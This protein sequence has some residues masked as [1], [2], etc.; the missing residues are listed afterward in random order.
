[1]IGDPGMMSEGL[2]DGSEPMDPMA[3]ESEYPTAPGDE[4]VERNRPEPTPQRKALVDSLQKMVK[5]GKEHWDK[6]FRQME[7]DQRFCAGDQWPSE[8]KALAFNDS[9]DDRYVANI[10]L[11]H[12]QQKVASLYAKNPKV[13][14]RKRTKLLNTVWDGSMQ[15]LQQA[16]QTMQ[17][18]QMAQQAMMMMG[19]SM[20][21]GA[22]MPGQAP[23]APPGPNGE[24]GAPPPMPMPPPQMPDE[25]AV[26]EAQAVI[27]DAK[28]VKAQLEMQDRIARTLELLYQYEIDEQPSPFKSMMK[29]VIRRAATSGVG[30]IKLGFQRVMEPNAEVETRIADMQQ[31]LSTIER[32]SADIADNEVQTDGAEVEQLRLL[33]EDL[34]KETEIVV[35][36]GLLLT[37]PKPTAVIPDPRCVEL[38]SFLN[39]DWVAEE[40]IMSPNEVQEVYGI[41]V[42]TNYTSYTRQDVNTDYERAIR[43]VTY[44]GKDDAHISEGDSESCLVWEVWSKK[45]GLKYTIIDG[46]PDFACEPESPQEYTDRFWPFFLVAFNET[47]GRVYPTSDVALVRP[48]QL[49][50][51]RTRQGLREHRFANRPKIMYAEG[52]LSEEDLD[53]LKNHPVNALISISGLQPQQDIKTVLQPFTGVPVD[54][55]LYEVNPVFQDMLR[56]VG[57]QEA[58]LGGTAGQTATETSVAANSRAS[59]MGSAIDDIDSTLTELARAAGQ[60]LLLNVSEETVKEICGPGAVWPS[61]TKG[62]VARELTLEIEAGSSGRPNQQQELMAFEKLAPILMQ[63]PGI[64]PIAL[65]KEAIKR[66]DDRLDIDELIAEGMPSIT[67]Q[68]GAASGPPQT[69]P[70]GLLPGAQGPQGANNAPKPPP[71]SPSSA[72]PKPP[73]MNPTPG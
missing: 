39:A 13:I 2:L 15:S 46:Y 42:G 30:W 48:M 21:T 16:Q 60:I 28:N 36:E 31:R 47:D 62:E 22:P 43:M 35:R 56:S 17:Q 14:C 41:D 54:P 29:M 57:D 67:A 58:N 71:P 65:A 68:N 38:R 24:M 69:G 32:I 55:N 50:L 53:A 70:E 49:E 7:R 45:D 33:I 61:L 63:L 20:L 8:T 44:G 25:G 66:L 59:S 64:N 11:R 18:Q 72:A 34:K 4:V 26:M 27:T 5:T 6:T 1:M 3:L 51:N 52:L 23:P 19:A 73:P 40:F 9:Y 12:V 10:T 37:Y